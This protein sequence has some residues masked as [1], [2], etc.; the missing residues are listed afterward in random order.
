MSKML[1]AVVEEVK[2]RFTKADLPHPIKEARIRIGGLL[3]M[4]STEVFSQG[5]HKVTAMELAMI[6]N[7]IERRLKH[8]PVHRILGEREFYGMSLRI[9]RHTLE[10]RP[11]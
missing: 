6:E 7:A 11:D 10:P 1:R 9:S 8:E 4:S 2:T 3:G 5:D